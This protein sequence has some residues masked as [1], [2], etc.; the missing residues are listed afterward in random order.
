MD[1][2]WWLTVGAVVLL[3]LV[4]SLVDGI[5]RLNRGRGRPSPAPAEGARPPDPLP[6]PGEIWWAQVP[7]AQSTDDERARDRPCL[8]L[9]VRG[10]DA[11][12]IKITSNPASSDRAGV[13]ALP[14]GTAG[15]AH[16]RPSFLETDEPRD[17]ALWAFRRR[18]GEVDPA[19]WDQ[20]EY[21]A[22]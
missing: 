7:G 20:V 4:A 10:G 1:T 21:L 5:A 3:A 2:S 19:L 22:E 9:A 6:R 17:V 18:A 13:V 16:G 11:R 12:V 15:V 14:P 8:V